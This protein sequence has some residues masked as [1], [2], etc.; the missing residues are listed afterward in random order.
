MLEPKKSWLLISSISLAVT[1][2]FVSFAVF[3]GFI[4]FQIPSRAPKGLPTEF[5]IKGNRNSRIYHLPKCHNYNDISE[6]NIV[7]FKTE[8]EA[9][10]AGFRKARNC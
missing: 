10:L 4:S 9:K 2:F 6:Q 1:L 3:A 5:G 8:D 7:W